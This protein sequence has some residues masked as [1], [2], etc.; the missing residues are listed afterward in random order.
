MDRGT[1][2]LNWTWDWIGGPPKTRREPGSGTGSELEVAP[3]VNQ[4]RTRRW[5]GGGGTWAVRLL[6]SRRRTVWLNEACTW[7]RFADLNI[8]MAV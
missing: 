4:N 2:P 3:E 8:E 6:R 1:S 7:V 5:G